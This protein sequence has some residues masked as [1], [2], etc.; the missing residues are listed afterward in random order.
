MPEADV[1]EIHTSAT[2]TTERAATAPAATTTTAAAAT[3]R[4]RFAFWGF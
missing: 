1:G 4:N 3:V 2:I